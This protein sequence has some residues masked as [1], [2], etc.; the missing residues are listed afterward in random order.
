MLVIMEISGP[1]S[2][3]F[4]AIPDWYPIVNLRG[5][6]Y[7]EVDVNFNG[8]VR[9]LKESICEMFPDDRARPENIRL[10]YIDANFVNNDILRLVGLDGNFVWSNIMITGRNSAY[11]GKYKTKKRNKKQVK[12]SKK[13]KTRRR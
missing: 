10:S 8:T 7:V 1:I 13:R 2:H 12:K 5:R 4:P 6:K 3:G 9:E 11:G